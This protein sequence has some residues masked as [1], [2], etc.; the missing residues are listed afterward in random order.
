ML[1]RLNNVTESDNNITQHP[2]KQVYLSH[3]EA[4][5]ET[6]IWYGS[7]IQLSTSL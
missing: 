2:P 3:F 7:I 4:N 6:E 5:M 1:K